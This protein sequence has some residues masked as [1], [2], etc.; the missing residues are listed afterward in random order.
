MPVRTSIKIRPRNLTSRVRNLTGPMS[1]QVMDEFIRQ[2]AVEGKRIY[3]KHVPV[4]A[5]GNMRESV[6]IIEKQTKSGGLD[7][8]ANIIIGPTIDY[9][10]FVDQG[11]VESPGM[12]VP[13]LGVR[14]KRGIHPGQSGQNFNEAAAKE[15]GMQSENL[16][17]DKFFNKLKRAVNRSLP[18]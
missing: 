5:T 1:T 12:Y 7:K 14:I 3:K 13:I 2:A 6:D 4:G 9:A 8:R 16:L 17:R 15:I 11:T 18:G 10:S